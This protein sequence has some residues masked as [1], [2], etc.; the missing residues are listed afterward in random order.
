MLAGTLRE[1]VIATISDREAK[2]R[3]AMVEAKTI[4]EDFRAQSLGGVEV[5]LV[6][7]QAGIVPSLIYNSCTWTDISPVAEERL[8]ELQYQYLRLLLAVPRSCP[9]VALRQQTGLISM[10]YRVRQEK[11]MF[12][13]H[14][15]GL[16]VKTLAFMVYKEQLANKW[17]GLARGV[18]VMC[19]TLNNQHPLCPQHRTW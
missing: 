16:D 4:I 9:K 13:H 19:D 10:K 18:T 17:P 7:W 3:G 6:L 11:I 2:V 12:V 1:S 15:K 14:L 8:E 5:G